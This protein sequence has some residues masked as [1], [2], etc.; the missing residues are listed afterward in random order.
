M[1]LT[2]FPTVRKFFHWN[3]WVVSLALFAGLILSILS[4]LEI[5][6]EHCSANQ[7]Y[8][9]FGFPFA[10][11][12]MIFFTVLVLLHL[13]SRKYHVLAQWVEWSIAAGL[14]AEIMFIA[15]QKYQIRQWCPVCLSIATSLAVAGL[16]YLVGYIHSLYDIQHNNRGDMM[17]KFKQGLTSLSFIVLGFLMAFIGVSKP[18]TAA[19]AINDMKERLAFGKKNSPIEIYFV[20]DWFCPSCKKV[21]PLIEKIFPEVISQATFY[22]I[23]YPIHKKSMNFTPYNLA[24]LVNNKSQYFK[25]RQALSELTEET[26]TPTDQD[27]IKMARKHG[28]VFK[29]LAFLDVKNGMDYF[30]KIVE[31]YDLNSTPTLIITNTRNN[32]TIK[33]EGRD[34]ISEDKVLKALESIN[35]TR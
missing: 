14:G 20:S 24:F 6:V 32:R 35:S 17:N 19:A 34:E 13:L 2:F 26:E 8:H 18:D 4:W 31:K 28:L 9:L 33:L 3:F 22:F 29:E 11:V 5:C 30:D 27:V 7:D 16:P 21:E 23:D 1:Q 15:I 25:A 12:G 10:I